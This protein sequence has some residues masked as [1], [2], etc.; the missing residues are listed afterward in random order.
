MFIHE[1]H[2][3]CAAVIRVIEAAA[4]AA[5]STNP[6]EAV[7]LALLASLLRERPATLVTGGAA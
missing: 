6:M 5:V 2:P 1:L 7:R 3:I 4:L